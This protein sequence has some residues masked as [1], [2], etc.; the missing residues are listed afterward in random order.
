MKVKVIQ[1]I[2]DGD[3]CKGCIF[4]RSST[5]YDMDGPSVSMRCI[6]FNR[7]EFALTNSTNLYMRKCDK[8]RS[9]KDG[10]EINI[11]DNTLLEIKGE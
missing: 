11:T 3:T 1:T 2:P 4:Y 9:L 5:S 8:C 10:D 7:V 6:L